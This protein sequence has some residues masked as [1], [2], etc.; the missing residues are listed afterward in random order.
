LVRSWMTQRKSFALVTDKLPDNVLMVGLIKQ[1]FPNARIIH[2]RRHPLDVGVS[3]FLTLFA[4]PAPYVSRLDWLGYRIRM[5]ERLVELWPRAVDL[6]ILNVSYEALVANPELEIRRIVEFA[7][8][9]WRDEFLTPEQSRRNVQTA[10]EWQVRQPI[11][12][13]SVARW[14]RYEP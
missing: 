7:G 13:S 8:L 1:L 11:Y 12:R 6:P 5:V 4:Q 9:D 2:A 14:H 3:N 10:S